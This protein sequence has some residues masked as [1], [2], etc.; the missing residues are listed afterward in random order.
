MA[1]VQPNVRVFMTG[2]YN[3]IFNA[4]QQA[5]AGVEALIEQADWQRGTVVGR[6][7][8]RPHTAGVRLTCTIWRVDMQNNWRLELALAP[9][10]SAEW[11]N[12]VGLQDLTTRFVTALGRW[13]GQ[14]FTITGY[15]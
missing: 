7:P 10:N 12:P 11:L 4:A 15:G 2:D 6:T 3:A 13:H 5:L 14:G 9:V 1:A 8:Q